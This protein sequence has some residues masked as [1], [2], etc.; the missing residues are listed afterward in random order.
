M[1]TPA[2]RQIARTIAALSRETRALSRASQAARR[3]V[4]ITDGSVSYYD[5]DGVERLAIGPQEDGGFLVT[6]LNGPPPPQPTAPDVIPTSG[7][8]VVR[9]DGTYEEANIPSDFSHTE[10]HASVTEDFVADDSTQI[11]T[12]PSSLG[13]EVFYALPAEYGDRYFALVAVSRSAQESVPSDAIVGAGLAIEGVPG[14]PGADGQPTYTWVKYADSPTTGMSDLPDGKTYLGLSYNHSDPAESSNYADYLWSLIQGPQGDP[15]VPGVPGPP[16]ADG[17]PTFTWVKYADTPTTGM[18][19]LPTGK[20]YIGFAYNKATAVESSNYADYGWSLIV[21]PQGVPGPPGADGQPTYTWLKYATTP[22]TGMSDDPTGKAYMGLAY[23]KTTAVESNVY[24]D[25]SWSLIQGSQGVPGPPGAD[26]TPRYT[27]IKYGTSAAG[28]GMSDSPTG[29]TYMGIAYNKTTAVESS[30]PGDYE[31]S[32]IQGPQGPPGDPA[33]LPES[34]YPTTAPSSSPAV[35]LSGTIDALVARAAP[36]AATTWLRFEVTTVDPET[37]A[38]GAW[39]AMP[40]MPT[41]STIITIAQIGDAPLSPGVAYAVRAVA[42][43]DIDEA[44]PGLPGVASLDPTVA[45]EQVMVSISAGF[46]LFGQLSVGGDAITLDPAEGLK[47]THSNGLVTRLAED[48]AE[49]AAYLTALGLTVTGSADFNARVQFNE[50]AILA[51]GISDPVT[52]PTMARSWTNVWLDL[53]GVSRETTRGLCE[54]IGASGDWAF[55]QTYYGKGTIYRTVGKTTGEVWWLHDVS[56]WGDNYYPEGLARD[57]AHYYVVGRD[58]S[59]SAR[60]FVYKIDGTTLARV[61][62][63]EVLSPGS[64]RNTIGVNAAGQVIVAW[65]RNNSTQFRVRTYTTAGVEV[66]TR[67]YEHTLGKVVDLAAVL[68]GIFDYGGVTESTLIVPTTGATVYAY[69]KTVLA[70]MTTR[71]FGTADTAR[72]NGMTWDGTRMHHLDWDGYVRTYGAGNP[73]TRT[74]YG[75]YTWDDRNSTGGLHRTAGSQLATYTWP[76]RSF[77]VIE[78]RPAP[79][80]GITDPL[81]TDIAD[82]VCIWAGFSESGTPTTRLQQTLAKGKVQ[83]VIDIVDVGSLVCPTVSTFTAGIGTA[84]KIESAAPALD[85]GLPAISLVGDGSGR[86]GPLRWNIAGELTLDSGLLTTTGT[87]AGNIRLVKIGQ[88]VF[89][90]GGIGRATG[91]QTGFTAVGLI[92]PAAYRPNTNRFGPGCVAHANSAGTYQFRIDAD[93]NVNV[94]QGAAITIDMQCNFQYFIN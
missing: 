27:W 60:V 16:G 79:D 72:V 90:A 15:G 49:I 92:I 44:A 26:G 37:E 62:Q 4:E 56:S 10:I 1:T 3:S 23:N 19:D 77:L 87:F 41:A 2:E 75:R 55:L 6:E 89:V 63:W 80:V 51:N 61:A 91:F 42:G 45:T 59:R 48:A 52:P 50:K 21:G 66:V 84:G 71:D 81:R 22:T 13:G 58:N 29:K 18:S 86:A 9:Y 40:D 39:V 11:G 31:W 83:A 14:P 53:H 7:G 70:R 24:A 54:R 93:G 17:S 25:Y 38:F 28:A 46:G 8:V 64:G 78:G 20:P 68:E 74:V 36:I 30:T 88:M 76:A 5:E 35:T 12:F 94:R 32:L 43:N 69:N 85:D 57:A 65:G 82:R 67:D 47:I 34:V 73:S 33:D